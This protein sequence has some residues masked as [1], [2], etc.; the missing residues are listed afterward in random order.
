MLKRVNSTRNLSFLPVISSFAGF[1]YSLIAPGVKLADQMERNE[2]HRPISN[3]EAIISSTKDNR[4][5]LPTWLKRDKPLYPGHVPLFAHERA[6][7][8]FGSAIGSLLNPENNN[9]IVTL[10][11]ST[12]T[13]KFLNSLRTKMLHNPTGRRI[14]RERP[15]ITSE[16]LEMV[17]L[18]KYP[19][20]SFG[21]VYYEWMKTNGVSPDT[22]VDVRYIDNE[23][24]SFIFQRYRQG[25]DFIHTLANLPIW[26][27]G[28]IAVKWFE[29]L[30]MGVPFAGMGAVF[31]PWTVKK[32]SERERLFNIYYPWALECTSNMESK[33]ICLINVMWEEILDR[34][35][36]ELRNELGITVPPN[37]RSLRK[38]HITSL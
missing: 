38:N 9:Y 32:S 11:E 30:N 29:Y 23:E 17:K 15:Y 35:V 8:F 25:H 31:S 1:A 18:A 27:E 7:M 24:L 22:R 3:N 5:E 14:L 13:E 16:S 28:E 10:G 21:R 4:R 36:D 26:R 33:G 20:N 6:M 34:D 19:P 12:A 37:M 2:L